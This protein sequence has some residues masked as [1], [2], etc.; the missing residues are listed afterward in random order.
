MFNTERTKNLRTPTPEKYL[1]ESFREWQHKVIPDHEQPRQEIV[2]QFSIVALQIDYPKQRRKLQK[3]GI[4]S[5]I[6]LVGTDETMKLL[7]F[8][9]N[10]SDY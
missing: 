4:Q 8:Q 9:V 5:P 10:T 1:S 3:G 7:L 2:A 6:M